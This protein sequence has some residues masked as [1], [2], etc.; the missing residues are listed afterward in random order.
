MNVSGGSAA[1]RAAL[2][3]ESLAQLPQPR[4]EASFIDL[5]HLDANQGLARLLTAMRRLPARRTLATDRHS[6]WEP[7]VLVVDHAEVL[8]GREAHVTAAAE[9]EAVMVIALSP[10][11][12]AGA[13]IASLSLGPTDHRPGST[14]LDGAPLGPEEYAA[15]ARRAALHR[16]AGDDR[17]AIALLATTYDAARRA[18]YELERVNAPMAARLAIDLLP[19]ADR[20][21][22]EDVIGDVIERMLARSDT[23]LEVK[24]DGFTWLAL[25]ES[26]APDAVQRVPRIQKNL[27]TGVAIAEALGRE[28]ELLLPRLAEVLTLGVLRDYDRAGR[29]AD[30]GLAI[31]RALGLEGWEARFEFG[32][33]TIRHVLG[34]N[35][36]A[37]DMA[38]SAWQRA[39]RAGDQKATIYSAL[40]LGRLPSTRPDSPGGLAALRDA[41]DLSR[42]LSDRRLESFTLVLLALQALQSEH[43]L[44]AAQW[45]MERYRLVARNRNGNA[46][47]PHVLLTLGLS[48]RMGHPAVTARLHGSLLQWTELILAALPAVLQARYYEAVAVA[49]AALGDADFDRCAEDGA[50]LS[51][52]SAAV[53]AMDY[54]LRLANP[55]Q[56]GALAAPPA[57]EELTARERDVLRLLVSGHR[58]KEI[59][60]RL[61]LSP[62][63]VMH[64][65][66]AI[67]RK[68]GVR[69]RAEAAVAAMRV[70]IIPPA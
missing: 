50:H 33:A 28:D 5:D 12:L 39:Q 1:D 9:R 59:A 69:G 54:A 22:D 14:S 57:A 2:V 8:S 38:M 70:G 32:V 25:I 45:L 42:E 23:P 35:R 53:E 58:N 63:T 52:E 27:D 4:P 36:D 6:T 37:T 30:D 49:R 7:E 15:I 65:T 34:D 18:I 31:A 41:L 64:H 19:E 21:G 40:L 16:A 11:R 3:T 48:A 56:A 46:L 67:Y 62:K 51:L 66:S 20:R 60:E 29:S 43:P 10:H 24:R 17:S 44:G 68:L 47:V 13:L 61:V 26:F 55:G